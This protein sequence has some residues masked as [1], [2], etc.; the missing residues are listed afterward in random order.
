MDS[1]GDVRWLTYPE[2]AALLGIS[3]EGVQRRV[4][5]RNWARQKGND[6]RMRIAVPLD[7]VP[8][9]YPNSRPN[10]PNDGSALR[11]Q[12]AAAVERAE[13]AETALIE[14]R[15]RADQ[16][17]GVGH[18]LRRRAERAEAQVD[19]VRQERDTAWGE[20]AAQ[21]ERAVVAESQFEAERI[22]SGHRGEELTEQRARAARAEGQA[23]E[24]QQ[25]IAAVAAE[26]D[27][28][29]MPVECSAEVPR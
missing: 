22:V 8:D 14:E 20:A 7:V 23:A 10:N 29:S 28:V 19:R 6:G 24:R 3:E 12:L 26:R 11:A 9:S 16:A 25:R 13:R 1:E 27:T 18:E 21:R 2:A 4:Q 15:R 17:E 5:R